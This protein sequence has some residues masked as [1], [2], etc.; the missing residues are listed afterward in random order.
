MF[1][2]KAKVSEKVFGIGLGRT[3]TKSLCTALDILG[4]KTIHMPLNPIKESYNCDAMADTPVAINYQ[5]LFKLY[6]NSKFI[7]TIRDEESWLR[8]WSEHY[9]RQEKRFEGGRPV[10]LEKWRKEI[11][12]QWEFDDLVW[13]QAY[14]RHLESLR[15]FFE[16]KPKQYLEYNFVGGD[17]WDKICK[18]L[19]KEVPTQEFPK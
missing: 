19:K 11:F 17:G 7:C 4:Y 10:I 18:F 15:S 5:E 13:I 6:S 3:G 1:W 12:G 8:S 16:D 14:Y 9:Q 2:K